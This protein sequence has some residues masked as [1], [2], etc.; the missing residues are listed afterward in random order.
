MV[1]LDEKQ[2]TSIDDIV[3]DRG[4]KYVKVAEKIGVSYNNFWGMRNDVE[5]I[6]FRHMKKLAE[7]LDV[8][9]S[10]IFE[11][12]RLTDKVQHNNH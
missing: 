4:L 6:S 10:V 5:R 9:V 3:L 8:D 2:Y 11:V 12:I 1:E 7:V